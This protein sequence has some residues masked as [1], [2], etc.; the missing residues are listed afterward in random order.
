VDFPV[1]SWI[2]TLSAST[3]LS[4]L[5]LA[6]A[7]LVWRRLAGALHDPLEL[8]ALAVAAC[9]L[10][11]AG[12]SVRLLWAGGLARHT[13]GRWW[14]DRLVLLAP[15][16]A[17]LVA[18]FSLSVSGTTAAGLAV[19]WGLIAAEE[20]YC[21]VARVSFRPAK[22]VLNAVPLDDG[23]DDDRADD[24]R[25]DAVVTQQLVRTKGRDGAESMSGLL[26]ANFSVGQRFATV[27]VAFCPSF[28]NVPK[29][30]IEQIDGPP[31]KIKTVQLLPYGARFDLKLSRDADEPFDVALRFSA[32]A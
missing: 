20:V 5:G 28:S 2:K 14:C 32:R 23:A 6:A 21:L 13:P 30:E 9:V 12:L 4:L 17:I 8:P 29:L 15:T 22:T 1:T 16:M 31:G 25:A 7:I 11:A 10:A 18:G 27:H 19:L 24:N 3:L 26:R